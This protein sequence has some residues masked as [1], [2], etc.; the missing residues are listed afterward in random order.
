VEPAVSI[1]TAELLG[2][3][4]GSETRYGR[5]PNKRTTMTG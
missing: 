3:V 5:G 2:T 4:C 1:V